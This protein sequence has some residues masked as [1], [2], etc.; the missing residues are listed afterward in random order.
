M[1]ARRTAISAVSLA[2]LLA[3][4]AVAQTPVPQIQTDLDCYVD[5]GAGSKRE[6]RPV[7]LSGNNFD[8]DADY[9]ISLDGQPIPGGTGKTTALG[10]FGPGSFTPPSLAALNRHQRKWTVRV[11]QG[12]KSA[13]TSFF[14]S[15][16]FAETKPSSGNP[17]TLKVRFS[18]F[19]FN[20]EQ[21]PVK[22]SVYVHYIRPNGKRKRTVRLGTAVGAC[23]E[24]KPTA[25]RRLFP[26]KAEKGLWKLQ[27][28][29]N[30]TFK[31]G[32]SQSPFTFYTIGVRIKT[33]FK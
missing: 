2:T 11:D 10:A 22:P 20:L 27:V 1:T 30:K 24:L 14:T 31:R 5:I 28:D 18:A 15:D 25:K 33:V 19:G 6:A 4:P 8:P 12:A 3:V 7:E 29:T 32:T 16:I 26:F 9:Q 17:A 21:R 13:T 23:G